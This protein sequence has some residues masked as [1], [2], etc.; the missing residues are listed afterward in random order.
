MQLISCRSRTHFVLPLIN[1]ECNCCVQIHLVLCSKA[2]FV[3]L[4]IFSKIV[5]PV[6]KVILRPMIQTPH[7]HPAKTLSGR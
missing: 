3:Q 7:I 4:Q 1:A 6:P 5:L 2:L